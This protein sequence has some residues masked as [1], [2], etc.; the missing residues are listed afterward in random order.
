MSLVR[1][2]YEASLSIEGTEDNNDEVTFGHESASGIDRVT[3]SR[4]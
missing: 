4:R 1:S 3:G 2:H